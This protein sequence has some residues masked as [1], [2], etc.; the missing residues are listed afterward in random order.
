MDPVTPM[1]DAG[2]DV[3]L[4]RDSSPPSEASP[5]LDVDANDGGDGSEGSG[6]E[7]PAER[8]ACRPPLDTSICL[9]S[10]DDLPP[11]P[12]GLRVYVGPIGDYLAY[13]VSFADI[14]PLGGPS[15]ICI[16][17]TATHALVGAWTIGDYLRYCCQSSLDQYQGIVTDAMIDA[18]FMMSTH[19]PCAD[20]GDVDADDDA[21]GGR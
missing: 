16:Y 6:C 1:A 11:P 13:Y 18:A 4:A 14:P 15:S 3:V 20:A 21:G 2:A 10:W 8:R 7:A 5:S 12:C 19:P 17:D 9:G